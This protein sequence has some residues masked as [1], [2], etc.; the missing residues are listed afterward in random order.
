[1]L[2]SKPAIRIRIRPI[3]PEDLPAVEA[4]VLAVFQAASIDHKIQARFGGA[5]WERVKGAVVRRQAEA[6]LQSGGDN[7]CFVA[8]SGK[9]IVGYVSTA[10]NHEASRGTI[11][12]LAVAADCQGQGLG[13]KLIQQALKF[14]RKKKL[15]QA[16]IE[17]L[18]TNL[19]GQH[20]YPKLGFVEVARQ[21]HYAMPLGRPKAGVGVKT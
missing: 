12:D 6:A 20:L 21:I 1:M 19:A 17:T 4:L 15:H 3:T 11:C 18:D 2:P 14:F 10:I 13:A 7:G 16:K 9:R 8:V 5:P